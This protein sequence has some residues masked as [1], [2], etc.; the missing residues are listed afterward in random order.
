MQRSG[1]RVEHNV[2]SEREAH[3]CVARQSN[4]SRA[5]TCPIPRRDGLNRCSLRLNT[6]LRKDIRNRHPQPIRRLPSTPVDCSVSP[7]EYQGRET[8][9]PEKRVSH[10]SSRMTS[11]HSS[12]DQPAERIYAV[13]FHRIRPRK[14]CGSS[15]SG[16]LK[17]RRCRRTAVEAYGKL[18]RASRGHVRVED[19]RRR[20]C[21]G[22]IAETNGPSKVQIVGF[23]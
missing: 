8:T 4:A 15:R 9:A 12:R 17:V 20:D 19:L 23:G 13:P 14:R 10:E 18:A 21:A 11:D 16:W 6:G 22:P 1:R 2:S 3:A 5:P 7:A